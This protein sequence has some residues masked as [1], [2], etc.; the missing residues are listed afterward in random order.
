MKKL[1]FS[2]ILVLLF[3]GCSPK[4]VGTWN[5]DRYEVDNY[6][7][8]NVS[9]TNA[10]EIV[11]NKNG[12]GEKNLFYTMFNEEYK[13]EQTFRWNLKDNILR[14][15]DTKGKANSDFAKS[16]IVVTNKSKKQVWKS[17][18]GS[19]SVQVIELRKK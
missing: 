16:W 1:L 17:T 7:G 10:G 14:I 12:T 13:D 2:T 4:I 19:N 9:S 6:K 3:T 8:Q 11:V 5:I 18:D 15:Y